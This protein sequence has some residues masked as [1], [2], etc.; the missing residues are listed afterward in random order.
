MK[1]EISEFFALQ[2]RDERSPKY[3]ER[4]SKGMQLSD[5]KTRWKSLFLACTTPKS[6]YRILDTAF[7]SIC[8]F[9][10]GEQKIRDALRLH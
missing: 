1:S 5:D 7:H 10:L 8:V 9:D 3:A 4:K 6:R 2:Y